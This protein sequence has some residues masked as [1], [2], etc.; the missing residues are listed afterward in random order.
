MKRTIYETPQSQTFLLET[1]TSI[2][3]ASK[4]V[5][6]EALTEDEYEPGI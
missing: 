1:D 4:M 6:I 2:C 5:T 3:E